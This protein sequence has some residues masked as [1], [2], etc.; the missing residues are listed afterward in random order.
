MQI[1]WVRRG[2]LGLGRFR[3][4]FGRLGR[5][6]FTAAALTRA[7]RGDAFRRKLAVFETF[8]ELLLTFIK[9]V[10]GA[11]Q[12]FRRRSDI[13]LHFVQRTRL[14]RS[15][16]LLAVGAFVRLQTA[17]GALALDERTRRF[18]CEWTLVDSALRYEIVGPFRSVIFTGEGGRVAR[19]SVP[20]DLVPHARGHRARIA[21]R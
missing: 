20:A 9:T 7:S 21:H 10:L 3:R 19:T 1:D 17:A 6:S 13:N 15:P 4:L 12:H 14:Q 16:V 5:R 11:F 2:T 8:V 18:R